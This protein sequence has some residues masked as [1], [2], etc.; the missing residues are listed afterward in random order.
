MT[1]AC[2]LT[3]T[4]HAAI[5]YVL[6]DDRVHVLTIGMRYPAEIDANIES[7]AGDTTYSNE[8]RGLLAGVSAAVLSDENVKK[9][10]V[11]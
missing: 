7:V 1:C 4:F 10:I 2:W 11:E 8:D 3:D 9:M 6:Q 5:R